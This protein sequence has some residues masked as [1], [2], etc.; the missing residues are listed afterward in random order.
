MNKTIITLLAAAILSG[1]AGISAAEN[2]QTFTGK[3]SHLK[4]S[5]GVNVTYIPPS[6]GSTT[7]K[8]DLDELDTL[9]GTCDLDGGGAGGGGDVG[10][11][12]TCG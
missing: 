2:T 7:V 4:S 12:Y 6:S 5:T 3:I 9:V 10:D 1:T 8:I 11:V